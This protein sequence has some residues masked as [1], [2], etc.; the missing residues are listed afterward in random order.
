M[1]TQDSVAVAQGF[2]ALQH[3]E[4]S[5]TRSELPSLDL[6]QDGQEVPEIFN[7]LKN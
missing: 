1:D 5:Q 6:P 7:V 2:S 3:V 4:S